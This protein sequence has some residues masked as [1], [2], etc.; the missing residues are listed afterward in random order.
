MPTN[1]DWM[2][3]VNIKNKTFVLC[4]G[5]QKAGTSWL[6]DF[7]KDIKGVNFG[8]RKEYSVFDRLQFNEFLQEDVNYLR[9][10]EAS[11]NLLEHADLWKRFSM[12]SNQME[13]FNYFQHI[14]A[15]NDTVLTGDFT[16]T[17]SLL[18]LNYLELIKRNF[19][20]I[21]VNTKV[22][23]LMRDPVERIWS[24]NRMTARVYGKEIPLV[25]SHKAKFVEML[26]RY[27]NIVPKIQSVFD[28]EDVYFNFY[29][30]LFNEKT[31]QE[32]LSFL[33]LPNTRANFSKR[34]NASTYTEIE[35]MI[36]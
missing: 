28:Q 26:T 24:A 25:G 12:M 19:S 1:F 20:N 16:P 22:I 2:Q 18:D 13:Y 31:I 14:L 21:G 29:E 32:I 9:K 30:N 23:F 4:L 33:N 5:T 6:W 36:E 34:V 3:V 27:E 10:V 35:P 17:Y 8:Y 11:K 15:A 7:I